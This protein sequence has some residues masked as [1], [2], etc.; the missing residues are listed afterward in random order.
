MRKHI[1][2]YLL[3]FFIAFQGSVSVHAFQLPCPMS[4]DSNHSMSTEISAETLSDC[5]N[6]DE[7][8]KKTGK[9]CKSDKRCAFSSILITPPQS[10]HMPISFASD[11]VPTL[12]TLF[13]SFE[14]FGVWRP[15]SFS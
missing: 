7:T 9:L 2:V 8:V 11:P 6:D 4:Q 15:P 10:T 14:P 13:A 3:F 1:W 12:T 5:C